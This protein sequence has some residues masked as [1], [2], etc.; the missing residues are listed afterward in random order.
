MSKRITLRDIAAKAGVHYTTVSMA[1]KNHPRISS[2][3]TKRIQALSKKMGYV[4][5][6]MLSA[7]SFYRRSKR[8]THYQSTLAWVDNWPKGT[9]LRREPTFND[10][11]IGATNRA[12]ELGYRIEEFRLQDA[13]MSS[14][15]ISSV[16]LSRGIEGILL[17]PQFQ[18]GTYIPFEFENFS[19][20]TFG[21]SFQPA[22]FHS[23]SNHQFHSMAQVLRKTTALGYQKIGFFMD[24]LIDEKVDG[25]YGLGFLG[26]FQKN[27]QFSFLKP[28]LIENPGDDLCR[29]FKK[30][31]SKEK[32]DLII[33]SGDWPMLLWLKEM[34]LS[35]PRDVGYARLSVSQNDIIHSG[36][37]ENGLLIGKISVD[38]LISLIQTREKGIPRVPVRL[39]VEGEWKQGKTLSV[40]K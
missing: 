35:V 4:P 20:L 32:P 24:K 36:I 12:Q 13:G 28:I 25:A 33:S 8:L 37:Y 34:G 30:W 39:M 17:A 7:L 11:Y 15:K 27:P 22:I 18:H 9:R 23:I 1:L 3:V 19:I 5:D 29:L 16:L 6:P 2:Q 40:Y 14:E 26:F 31:F 21:S 10:Y 38:Y